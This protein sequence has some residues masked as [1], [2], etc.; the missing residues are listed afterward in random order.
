M[1]ASEIRR[2][3]IDYFAKQQHVPRPSASLVPAD[4]PTLLFVNA[5]MVP[6]KKVF[7]GMEEPP[8]G[9]RRATTAH[10]E[11]RAINASTMG[12]SSGI[13]VGYRARTMST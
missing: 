10:T 8:D 7:L 6:F 1:R 11:P 13:I 2:R 9:N 5:G 12:G 3:F 4:D